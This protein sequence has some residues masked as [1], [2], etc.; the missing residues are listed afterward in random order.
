MQVLSWTIVLLSQWILRKVQGLERQVDF[1]DLGPVGAVMKTL[2]YGMGGGTVGGVVKPPYQT[3]FSTPID[4]TPVKSKPP[5]YS[6]YSPYELARNQSL[7]VDQTG[8]RSKRKPALKTAMKTKKIF[9][10]GD[11]YFNV[12][13]VKFSLLVT[14]KIVD[15]INGTFTVYFRHNSSS[16]GN[17]SVSIVPPTKVVEFEVLQ[18]HHLHPHT[19]QDVQIQET[20]QSTIDPKE[21]KTLNCRVEYEKTNR[22]KKSKPC[23]YDPS[24]TCFTE[25]T[26]SHAAWLCAKPFKVICIFIS[27]FSIDYKLVQKVCPDYNFQSDHPYFG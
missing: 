5:P 20:Q 15:H 25:H 13:T 1:S 11:F 8:Y 19:Q 12:K 23:L 14:G 22:S 10:W 26:Q 16:L 17:V 3:I 27:F 24:Q 21:A 6:S 2:P 9:G 7:L 4:Q 18:Q